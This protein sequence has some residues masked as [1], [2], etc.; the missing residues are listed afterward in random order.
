MRSTR[1]NKAVSLQCREARQCYGDEVPSIMVVMGETNED[2]Q[3]EEQVPEQQSAQD[4]TP[5]EDKP[6]Y[7]PD[8]S[9]NIR[10]LPED[11]TEQVE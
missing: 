1:Q 2:T 10:T 4:T 9:R 6:V 8:G 5:W 3:P 7:T 11:E